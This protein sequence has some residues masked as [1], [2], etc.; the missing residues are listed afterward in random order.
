MNAEDRLNLYK[1]IKDT[2]S[3]RPI[4]E[5]YL[6]KYKGSFSLST[7]LDVISELDESQ[8]AS[9]LASFSS[10]FIVDC[11]GIAAVKIG[12]HVK[13][14]LS[15]LKIIDYK[16]LSTLPALYA[17][18][19]VK[20][21]FDSEY[22]YS[23][24]KQSMIDIFSMYSHVTSV[25]LDK[26]GN[27]QVKTIMCDALLHRVID[28]IKYDS[29]VTYSKDIEISKLNIDEKC[30]YINNVA[31]AVYNNHFWYSTSDTISPSD[32]DINVLTNILLDMD[33]LVSDIPEWDT[34][35]KYIE[36]ISLLSNKGFDFNIFSA[37]TL[38]QYICANSITINELNTNI[39]F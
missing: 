20:A 32:E 25:L 13:N 36:N 39:E 2:D 26:N 37:Y 24:D 1:T 4:Y 9:K 21:W 11:L 10:N 8:I 34:L 6:Q 15:L 30:I 23:S 18:L 33:T 5:D 12:F 31:K 19:R 29:L 14:P 7:I 22:T 3:M 27:D 38:Y 28:K 35:R 17:G 16:N